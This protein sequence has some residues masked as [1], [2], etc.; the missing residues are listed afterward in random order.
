M[1]SKVSCVALHCMR[2]GTQSYEL[3]NDEYGVKLY[4]KYSCKLRISLSSCWNFCPHSCAKY[5]SHFGAHYLVCTNRKKNFP[6]CVC[7]ITQQ[8]KLHE[9]IYYCA[10]PGNVSKQ[11]IICHPLNVLKQKKTHGNLHSY[12]KDL[13]HRTCE[14][15]CWQPPTA[16]T[17]HGYVWKIGKFR[18][19][20]SCI[21]EAVLLIFQLKPKSGQVSP[22]LNDNVATR[23]KFSPTLYPQISPFRQII[24][25]RFQRNPRE[26]YL[27]LNLQDSSQHKSRK[28]FP[29]ADCLCF[30]PPSPSPTHTSKSGDCSKL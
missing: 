14:P 19:A 1:P 23:N 22:L 11:M 9:Q 20:N 25:P 26:A 8:R 5:I 29:G 3:I 24:L 18:A 4:E 15:W 28:W 27:L 10:Y 16:D 17:I 12:W 6:V 2:K 21:L 7:L 13:R 30:P